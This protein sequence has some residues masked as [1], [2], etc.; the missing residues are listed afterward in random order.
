MV[1]EL[2]HLCLPVHPLSINREHLLI[3]LTRAFGRVAVIFSFYLDVR[4]V[5]QNERPVIFGLTL[6]QKQAPVF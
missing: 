2:A 5:T 6:I 4:S 1:F 3:A